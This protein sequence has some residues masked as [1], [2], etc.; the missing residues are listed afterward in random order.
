MSRVYFRQFLSGNDFAQTDP[1]ASGMAN[2]VCAMG[3]FDTKEC[4]LVD[5]AWDAHGLIQ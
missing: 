3:G 2:F 1:N 5:P 4:Y